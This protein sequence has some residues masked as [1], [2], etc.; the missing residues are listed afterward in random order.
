MTEHRK[1]MVRA[2]RE[3][4]VPELRKR[5]FKG[6][7]PHFRRVSPKRVDYLSVQFY[8]AGGSFVVELAAAGPDGKPNGYGKHLPIEKLNVAYFAKRFRLGSDPDGGVVDH[9]YE[10][11][12]ASYE[13]PTP[14]P[15][16]E[17]FLR[18]AAEVVTHL[19]LQGESWLGAATQ[20]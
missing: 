17:H 6:S 2:L 11:G 8:S 16:Y 5:G 12:P 18:I 14:A 20:T 15:S 7:F 9:W 4:F 3:V 13:A 1:L 19:G 10:F